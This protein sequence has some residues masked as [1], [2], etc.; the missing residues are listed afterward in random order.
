MD[1][2]LPAGRNQVNSGPHWT[3][4]RDGRVITINEWT[5]PGGREE[6]R[7]SERREGY[8]TASAGELGIGLS[9]DERERPN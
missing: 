4:S 9:G 6:E 5:S 7:Q 2:G 3:Y 8:G 1:Y